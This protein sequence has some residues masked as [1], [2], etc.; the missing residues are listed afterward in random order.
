[1]K[2]YLSKKISIGLGVIMIF[3]TFSACTGW[4]KTSSGDS[5]SQNSVLSRENP[6][7]NDKKDEYIIKEAE[8]HDKVAEGMLGAAGVPVEEYG[9]YLG[10]GYS[11]FTA[12]FYNHGISKQGIRLL[13]EFLVERIWFISRISHPNM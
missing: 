11:I 12:A 3:L 1:M 13:I 10:Y 7:E 2:M 9:G 5:T 6:I 4:G 8:N